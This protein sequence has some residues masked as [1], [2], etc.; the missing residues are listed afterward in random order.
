[1]S[2]ILIDLR[3]TGLAKMKVEPM[4]VLGSSRIQL[5]LIHVASFILLVLVLTKQ[6]S[7][8]LLVVQVLLTHLFGP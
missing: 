4:C 1:M 5:E 6:C 7:C 8:L 3:R 2:N